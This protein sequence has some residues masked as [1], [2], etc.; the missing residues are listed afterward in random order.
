MDDS[1]SR[2]LPARVESGSTQRPAVVRSVGLLLARLETILIDGGIGEPVAEAREIVAALHDA[3][4]FWPVANAHL[5]VTDAFWHR[6][7]AAARRRASGAPNAYAVGRAGFRHLTL[8]VDERVLIPRPETELLVEFVLEELHG[9]QGGVVIDVG[10]GS[11]AIALAL[12]TEGTFERVFGTDI[13][14]DALRVAHTNLRRVQRQLK[15]PV[16]LVHGSLLAGLAKPAPRVIVSNPPY[17]AF[18]EAAALPKAVRDWEPSVAL[19]AGE[20][21]L[22]V[23]RRLVAEAAQALAPGGLLALE[24]DARRAALVAEMV[25]AE[26]RFAMVQVRLDLT[27]RERFVL[28]RRQERQ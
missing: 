28:A 16:Q 5:A 18:D 25:S 17:I 12:A 3:P 4:R 27:G 9:E 14:L 24:V 1:R 11:G 8:E 7:V 19:L 20:Q 21:G 26:R 2:R 22:S 23:T 15:S 6:A 13:S 10:T